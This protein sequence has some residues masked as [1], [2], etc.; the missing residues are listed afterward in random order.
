L[1]ADAAGFAV[2]ALAA[3][4]GGCAVGAAVVAIAVVAA[5]V[6]AAAVLVAGCLGD[7]S[8]RRGVV[9]AVAGSATGGVPTAFVAPSGTAGVVRT[10]A[11]GISALEGAVDVAEVDSAA[12]GA[13]DEVAVAVSP[14]ATGFSALPLPKATIAATAT[15]PAPTIAK[16]RA[17]GD[18]AVGGAVGEGAGLAEA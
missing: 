6:A 3:V 7:G 13:P 15:A 5:E 14:L 17:R 18:F 10:A 8:M 2:G 1:R 12:A 11:E 9:R 4:A 16:I